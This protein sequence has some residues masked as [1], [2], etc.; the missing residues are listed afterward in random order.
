[1]EPLY[2]FSV[3]GFAILRDVIMEHIYLRTGSLMLIQNMRSYI[4][5]KGIEMVQ[6]IDPGFYECL[7]DDIT[8]NE[9]VLFSISD[10]NLFV[11]GYIQLNENIEN[12]LK[13]NANSLKLKI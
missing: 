9:S 2:L 5:D 13:Q 6:K 7:F 10:V 8:S 1:M 12:D 4:G 3:E 11:N